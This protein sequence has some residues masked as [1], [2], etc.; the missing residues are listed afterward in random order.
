MKTSEF[1]KKLDEY[2]DKTLKVNNVFS[3]DENES[4]E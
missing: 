3:D 4:G 1:I 2:G